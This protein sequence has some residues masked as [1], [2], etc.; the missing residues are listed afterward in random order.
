M[1]IS[2]DY[3]DFSPMNHRFDILD[4]IR[5]RYPD[6]KVTMFTVPWEIRLS[7][8]TKG[9]PITHDRYKPWVDKV[10]EAVD[11]GWMDISLHGLTHAP[12]E[13]ENL[14][15]QEVKNRILTGQKMFENVGIKI[16]DLF[17]APQWLISED[18]KKAVEDLGLKLMEDHY[19]NWNLKD[20][21]PKKK[22]KL[23]AHG[24][25]Q[26]VMGNGLDESFFRLSKTPTDAEWLHLKEMI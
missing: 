6:F 7:P 24:H 13:M 18:G 25:V 12:R 21:K 17:K 1:K 23:I 5:E 2:C 19:Y 9:T 20:D 3:D 22:K 14:T 11:E 16:N 4:K 15:Y 26:D 10:I 8:S